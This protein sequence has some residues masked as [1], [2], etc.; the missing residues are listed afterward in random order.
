MTGIKVLQE[1][2]VFP[3]GNFKINRT[4]THAHTHTCREQ[5]SR[6]HDIFHDFDIEILQIIS[7]EFHC[8]PGLFQV[9]TDFPQAVSG[10]H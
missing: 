1:R 10:I 2:T 3:V 7:W 4:H 5:F 6:K 8:P 9:E